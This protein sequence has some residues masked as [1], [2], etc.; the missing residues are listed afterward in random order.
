MVKLKINS[1]G[2]DGIWVVCSRFMHSHGLSG[3]QHFRTQVTGNVGMRDMFGF[4]VIAKCGSE[5]GKE[6]A[7]RALVMVRSYSHYLCFYGLVKM[8]EIERLYPGE[9][10]TFKIKL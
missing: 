8:R 4:N 10:T 3:W 6:I 5:L 7:I 9:I 2:V 1:M